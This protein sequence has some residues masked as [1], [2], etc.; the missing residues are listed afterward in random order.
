MLYSEWTN[1]SCVWC[2]DVVGI[3][4]ASVVCDGYVK[5][6]VSMFITFRP[7]TAVKIF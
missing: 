7:C 1:G 2:L 4:A 6:G 3:G 5:Q